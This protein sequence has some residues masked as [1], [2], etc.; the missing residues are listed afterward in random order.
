VLKPV[1]FW[2]TSVLVTLCV[3]QTFTPQ[4]LLLE[5]KYKIAVW[6]ATHVEIA[7]ALAQLLR[8]NKI[9][10]AEY[11]HAKQ[12]AEHLAIIWRTAVP[13]ER[14]ALKARALLERNTLRAADALQLAAALEWCEDHPDGK[15]FLTFDQR[16]REAAGLAGFTL[17]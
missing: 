12:Q 2:D 6:W 16:L 17:Q 1:A 11:A 5:R 7:S 10:A 3:D 8:Q 4:A 13:S 15:I 9:T 14:I